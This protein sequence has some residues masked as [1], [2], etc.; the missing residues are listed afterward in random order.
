MI[1]VLFMGSNPAILIYGISKKAK[2]D[3]L[4]RIRQTNSLDTKLYSIENK[5]NLRFIRGSGRKQRS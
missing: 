1:K 3:S 2:F 4:D 5:K